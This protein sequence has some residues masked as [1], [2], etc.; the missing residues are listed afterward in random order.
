[1]ELQEASK[2]GAAMHA[3]KQ[4][5]FAEKSFDSA[6]EFLDTILETYRRE[7]LMDF[8][9]AGMGQVVFR[10]IDDS[11][12]TN[13]PRA[14]R[15]NTDW[16]VFDYYPPNPTHIS[17]D[18]RAKANFLFDHRHVELRSVFNFLNYSDKL[19]IPTPLNFFH[20]RSEMQN[21]LDLQKGK[22]TELLHRSPNFDY[23]FPGEQIREAFALAQHY[24]VPTRLL[25]WTESPLVAMFFAAA[26]PWKEV[27]GITKGTKKA[28]PVSVYGLGTSLTD[29][30]GLDL[31][32]ATRYQNSKLKSQRGLFTLD[33]NAD[34]Y[35]K[36]EGRWPSLEDRV[37]ELET[38]EKPATARFLTPG[39]MLL[40][41]NLV[42]R[43]C[44]KLAAL[45]LDYDVSLETMLP[46][47]ENAALAFAYRRKVVPRP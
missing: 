47:L 11:S 18:D 23:S 12:H 37:R 46:S 3:D 26:K 21:A 45:L 2:R 43:E 22:R 40:K 25:D 16:S 14:F 42:A 10:G 5:Y 6:A 30:L 15:D 8:V 32:Q 27:L 33:T 4:P 35:W 38:R 28:K 9:G 39:A 13:L 36:H 17:G 7:K 20:M 24:G 41:F 29:K 44:N 34:A 1:M 31:V 19:G